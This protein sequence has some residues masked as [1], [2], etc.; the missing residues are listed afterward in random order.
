MKV[1]LRPVAEKQLKKLPPS[2]H[3]K[4]ARK[5]Q[6]L[7]QDQAVGKLLQGE[8]AG[9]RSLRAWPYRIIYTVENQDAIV[10]FS[11]TNRQGAYQ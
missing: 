10:I 9:M 11:I 7:T 6:H 3:K 5:L 1:V 2:G 4:V 8:Y